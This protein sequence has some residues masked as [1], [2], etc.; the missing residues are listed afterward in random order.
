MANVPP[1]GG[2]KHPQQEYIQL[3]TTNILFILGGAF[4][5]LEKIIASRVDEKSIGFGAK[6]EDDQN[7]Q[8]Q[9][10]ANIMPEDL[11]KFGLIPEFIGRVPVTV[12]LKALDEDT[13]V[14]I[15]Q[16]PRNAL[17]KQYQK[18]LEYDGAEL[19]FTD[20]ALHAV[21]QEALKLKTGARG[22]R[23]VLESIMLDLMYDLPSRD[24]VC[25][26]MITPACILGQEPPKLVT[27]EEV[28]ASVDTEAE[29][30]ISDQSE[31]AGQEE[32]A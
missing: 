23:T 4:D 7:H 11:L 22:L 25:Q 27:K 13:L 8:D 5:G 31:R 1:Q 24:D 17:I 29:P 21:A 10:L 2:R 14:R 30:V 32:T 18:L 12:S 28:A 26:V 6:I 16:E 3:D 9:L 19:V 20:E 15:L